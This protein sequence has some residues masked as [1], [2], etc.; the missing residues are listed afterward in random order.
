MRTC[1][2]PFDRGGE[3]SAQHVGRQC[4]DLDLNQRAEPF[5]ESGL[6]RAWRSRRPRSELYVQERAL[7]HAC[8]DTLTRSRP[9][10]GS[11]EIL[12]GTENLALAGLLVVGADGIE[13]PTAGV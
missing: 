4:I 11:A 3:Q 9:A 7:G 12:V 10:G 1:P 2:I 5:D 13:P 8:T 6:P